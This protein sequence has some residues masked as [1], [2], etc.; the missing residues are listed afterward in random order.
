MGCAACAAGAGR[1]ATISRF[2]CP[3][4][5]GAPPVHSRVSSPSGNAANQFFGFLNASAQ[6]SAAK[7]LARAK[8]GSIDDVSRLGS[9]EFYVAGEGT[10]FTKVREPMCLSHHPASPPTTEEVIARAAAS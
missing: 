1:G 7:E 5:S 9:G 3:S 4:D 2:A 6:I 10:A 8:G